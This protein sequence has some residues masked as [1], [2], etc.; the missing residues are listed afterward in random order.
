M[1][2]PLNNPLDPT[3][4]TD[5]PDYAPGTTATIT[6]SGF[7]IGD[8]IDF[9][10]TVIDA[11]TGATLWSGPEWT[12]VEGSDANGSGFLTTLFQVTSAYGD[13]TIQLTATDL[14]VGSATYGQTATVV[15]TDSGNPPDAF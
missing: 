11:A 10:I 14:T 15:F 5:Q 2:D 8:T 13:T 9:Q 3:V 7:G 1:S 4:L 6:A 12:A